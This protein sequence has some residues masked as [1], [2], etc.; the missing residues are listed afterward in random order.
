MQKKVA[1]VLGGSGFIGSRLT[2]RLIA[3]G[4]WRVRI[5][6]M[7]EPR[8]QIEGVEHHPIDV[9]DPI[10]AE[11]GAEAEI[12]FNLAALHRTPGHP[13]QDYF[14][15]NIAGA[16][17]ATDLAEACDIKTIVFTSSISVYGPCEDLITEQSPLR[18]VTAYGESKRLAELVHKQ[19]SRRGDSRRLIITR[20]G[21]VFGPGEAG[22]YTQLAR[23]LRGGYF[24][25][26]GRRDTIK[27][28][29]SV[30]ELLST[31][32][33]A[34]GQPERDILYNFAYP[35]SSTTEAIVNIMRRL[36]GVRRRPLTLPLGPMLAAAL[37][38]EGLALV[39]LKTAIHRDRVMKLVQST[40]IRPD[41]L[42][43]KG[44]RFSTDIETALDLWRIETEG[45]FD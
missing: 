8:R 42:L 28:G 23:A 38:F 43:T 36:T 1:V 32:D 26:P 31:I 35:D 24:A 20:P 22:N 34:L 12:L 29:G 3:T 33:F 39:G 41:W 44:Y 16:I 13:D 4:A 19:W 11:L 40:R 7:V 17:N 27:S 45:R 18:P 30:D 15:T 2:Q 10:R 21:V 25:Y 9:R 6:D 14:Q 37:V 5:L